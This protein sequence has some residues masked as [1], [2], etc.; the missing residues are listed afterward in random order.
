MS[1]PS[2]EVSI[3]LNKVIFILFFLLRVLFF[4]LSFSRATASSCFFTGVEVKMRVA[5]LF[6]PPLDFLGCAFGNGEIYSGI[7]RN[8]EVELEDPG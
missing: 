7:T 4:F 6:L 3:S 5:P 2:L 1:L 8:P